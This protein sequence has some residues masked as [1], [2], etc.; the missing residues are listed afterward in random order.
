MLCP[1]CKI[2]LQE[3]IFYGVSVNYCP[4][5]LGLWFE[6]EELR[7]AKDEKDR[8]L[9]WLDIDL[10]RDQEKFKISP[11]QK[12]CPLD[13]LPLYETKYGDSDIKVD[14]CNICRGIWLDRGEFEEI[15][16]YLKKKKEW[17]V[18]YNYAK[19]FREEFWEIFSGPESWREEVD[20]FLAL[21]KLLSYKF[22]VQ[23]PNIAKIIA[24]LPR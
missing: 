19:N 12:L 7:W 9:R 21:L 5:C 16:H 11:G 23:H 18:L 1:L 14:L 15:I 8:E 3:A 22:A 2:G 13:R 4:R 17:E 10:W 24:G 6:E 20:D